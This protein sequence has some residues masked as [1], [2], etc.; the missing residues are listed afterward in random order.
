[1]FYPKRQETR[2]K[3]LFGKAYNAAASFDG[4]S[5]RDIFLT[6]QSH[7]WQAA[8][9]AL[10]FRFHGILTVFGKID[11]YNYTLIIL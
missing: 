7:L 3:T 11:F 2:Q 10:T 5:P 9:D 8:F 4:A 1:L 6:K